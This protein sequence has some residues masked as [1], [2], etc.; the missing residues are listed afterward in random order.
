MKSERKRRVYYDPRQ[1]KVVKTVPCYEKKG[2][3]NE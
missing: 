3:A 2:K 1:E